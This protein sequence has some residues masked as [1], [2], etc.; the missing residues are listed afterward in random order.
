MKQLLTHTALLLLGCLIYTTTQAQENYTEK[1]PGTDVSFDMVFINGGTFNMGSETDAEHYEETEG[2]PVE[3]TVD[4][5]WMGKFEVTYDLYILF[6]DRAQDN[7]LTAAEDK[8]F[9]ADAVTRPSPPYVDMSFGMGT[10]GGYPI[11]S[12]TQQSALFFCKW[13]YDKT[14]HFYRLPTEAEWEYAC[15]AGSDADYPE[16]D[17]EEVAWYFDNGDEEYQKVG[18]LEPNDWGL[19]DMLGNVSEWT[20]DNYEADYHEQL[21][22]GAKNPWM[23]PE[24]RYFR[25]VR[26]GAYDDDAEDCHCGARLS[27]HPNWQKRDPQIPK[28]LW[29]NTDSPFVG[30]RLVRPAEQPTEEEIAQFFVDAIKW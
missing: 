4:D 10:R 15:K 26:G 20:L 1:I 16:E 11:V 22:A 3:V 25:T 8:E 9:D 2:P 28:S 18:Q 12:T 27:S 21:E 24:A 13:L 7:N 17:L 5:F 23:K 30:F 14:G 6:Q 29:W 19:Y